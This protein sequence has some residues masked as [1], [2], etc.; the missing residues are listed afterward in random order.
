M[1]LFRLSQLRLEPFEWHPN[2]SARTT[3][4]AENFNAAAHKRG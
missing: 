4:T 3:K 1:F 2:F